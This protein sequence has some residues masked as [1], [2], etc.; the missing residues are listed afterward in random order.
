MIDVLYVGCF[1]HR[2]DE[3]QIDEHV[4]RG[5]PAVKRPL[6]WHVVEDCLQHAAIGIHWEAGT[7]RL[8]EKWLL[9]YEHGYLTFDR[10]ELTADAIGVIRRLVEQHGCEIVYP[11]TARFL[12]VDEVEEYSRRLAR[13]RRLPWGTEFENS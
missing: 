9:S 10:S 1:E 6:G 7:P 11:Q 4:H 5:H 2:D 12:T 8:P 13:R 3:V